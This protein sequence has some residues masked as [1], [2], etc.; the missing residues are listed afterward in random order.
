MPLIAALFL[1]A[2]APVA[3]GSKVALLGDVEVH[4]NSVFLS[5]LLPV[6]VSARV[7]TPAQTIL[8]GYAP[9]PGTARVFEGA[10]VAG[11]LGPEIASEMSIPQKIVV[12]R[13]GQRIT[14]DE[15]IAVI[16]AALRHNG[17]SGSD[18]QPDDLRIFPSVMAS[19]DHAELRVRRMDFDDVLGE[20]RFLMAE[21]GALPFL[22][23]AQLRNSVASSERTAGDV[24]GESLI[25]SGGLVPSQNRLEDLVERRSMRSSPSGTAPNSAQVGTVVLVEPGKTA[26]LHMSSS[27]IQMNLDVTPLERGALNQTIRVKL[28]ANGKVLQA[29]VTGV[30]RLEA[31]F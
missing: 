15:V 31:T 11:L 19:S 21:R 10:K 6:Q 14:R 12:H 17:L 27:A 28:P 3:H 18:L 16:R 25:S 13:A 5:D 24:H 1:G 4:E 29:Q 30:R 7:R 22:V 26:I 9:A 8:I 2:V 20:A 23:T